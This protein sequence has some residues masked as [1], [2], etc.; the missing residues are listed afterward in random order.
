MPPTSAAIIKPDHKAIDDYYNRLRDSHDQHAHHEGNVRRAFE[1]LLEDTAKIRSWK[2][3][4]EDSRR[5][6]GHGI[7]YDGTLRD[8]WALVYGHWE[9][10]DKSDNLDLE[11]RKKRERGYQFTNIIIENTREAVLFQD[12]LEVLRVD[13]QDRAA[14]AR[15]LTEFYRYDAPPLKNFDEA[16]A[17]FQEQIP[18]IAKELKER[19]DAAH[20]SNLKF[21]AAFEDFYTLCRSALN[22]NIR[23]DAVNEMLIQHMLTERLIRKIFDVEEFVRRNVIAS[24]IENVIDALTSKHFN[25]REFLGRLD[26]FYEAIEKA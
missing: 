18:Q 4:T 1:S 16:V 23:I 22:P 3:V 5:A 26:R 7:R 15:L 9:A 17:A 11:I 10:K 24:K 20:S 6:D 2:L 13:V 25:R 19:I 21:Q 14:L 12:G 8:E